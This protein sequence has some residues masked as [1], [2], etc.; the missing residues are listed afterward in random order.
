MIL[1]TR[2]NITKVFL[3]TKRGRELVM[4]ILSKTMSDSQ[5]ST[6][7][8]ITENQ[9]RYLRKNKLGIYFRKR[10]TQI[11]CNE[12]PKALISMSEEPSLLRP[13]RR[14][15]T[16]ILIELTEDQIDELT[17]IAEEQCRSVENQAKWMV[18]RSLGGE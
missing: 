4:D 8:D 9:V 18:I 10:R 11:N 7:Y 3:K 15:D 12:P 6:L 14:V 17:Y 13:R 16:K 1:K 2:K 5:I